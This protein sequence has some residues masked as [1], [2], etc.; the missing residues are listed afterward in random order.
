M[1]AASKLDQYN[2]IISENFESSGEHLPPLAPL[3]PPCILLLSL[4]HPPKQL[5]DDH[6]HSCTNFISTANPNSFTSLNAF[7]YCSANNGQVTVGTPNHMI[8]KIE[9]RPQCDTNPPNNL[10]AKMSTCGA[11]TAVVLY[12]YIGI[13]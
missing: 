3:S 2:I 11:F 6:H 12:R 4:S 8:S 5:Q 1:G 10:Y 7:N 13:F 9:F